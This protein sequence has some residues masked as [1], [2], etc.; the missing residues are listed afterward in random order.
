M[1]PDQLL[2][3]VTAR[4]E[5]IGISYCVGGSFAS[6]IYGQARTTYDLDILIDLKP[7]QIQELIAAFRSDFDLQATELLSAVQMAPTYRDTPEHRAIAKAYHRATQF[8]VDFFLAS[9]RPFEVSQLQRCVRHIIA[10]NPEVEANFAAPEDIILAKLEWF[11]LGNFA[12]SHQWPDVQ[13]MLLVQN[14]RLDRNYLRTWAI[15]LGILD[16]LERAQ[17]NERPP[18][19]PDAGD[20]KQ[21]RLFD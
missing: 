15:T 17:A 1:R 19:A 7:A 9:G 20:P 21:Q 5:A 2:V 3:V 6:G 12:S 18:S 14:Q 11:Q 10:T 8:R 13:T 16:L 4:L